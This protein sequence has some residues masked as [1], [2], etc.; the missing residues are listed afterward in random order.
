MGPIK[1]IQVSNNFW[2]SAEIQGFSIE[3]AK[4]SK[5]NNQL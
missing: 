4:I 3:T 5:N 1:N 2:F